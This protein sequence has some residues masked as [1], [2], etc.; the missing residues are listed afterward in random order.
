MCQFNKVNTYSKSFTITTHLFGHWYEN[1]LHIK[2]TFPMA[3]IQ[4]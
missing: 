3:A 1:Q 2:L 4:L